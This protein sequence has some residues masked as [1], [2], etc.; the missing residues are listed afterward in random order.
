MLELNPDI[1][2]AVENIKNGSAVGMGAPTSSARAAHLWWPISPSTA[3]QVRVQV[4]IA[5]LGNRDLM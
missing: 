5:S 1:D 2:A 4:V 3:K